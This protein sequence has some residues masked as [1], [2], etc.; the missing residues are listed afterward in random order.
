MR[1]RIVLLA[2]LIATQLI[3]GESSPAQ[4]EKSD[5]LKPFAPAAPWEV[6]LCKKL[7][8]KV[9]FEF[10]ETPFDEGLAFLRSMSNVSIIVDPK[11]TNGEV[12]QITLQ[13]ANVSIEDALLKIFSKVNAG[14]ELT[15]GALFIFKRG[16]YTR[17]APVPLTEKETTVFNAAIPLL[18]NDDFETRHKAMLSIEALG[19]GC[20]HLLEEARKHAKDAETAASI[21]TLIQ[22]MPD[23]SIFTQPDNVTKFLGDAKYSKNISVEFVDTPLAEGVAF[24]KN[25]AQMPLTVEHETDYRPVTLRVGDMELRR[26]LIWLVR[27]GGGKLAVKNDSLVIEKTSSAPADEAKK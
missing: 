4:K 15:D 16:A 23:A 3:A 19:A 22:N 9:S 25:L 6:E 14:Y 8:K 5:E 18:S 20:I 17:E 10:V 26:A 21:N 1:L 24:L 12:P 27:L 2:A 13:L 11:F 7:K